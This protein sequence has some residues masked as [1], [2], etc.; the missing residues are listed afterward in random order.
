MY[1]Y[2]SDPP[3]SFQRNHDHLI[4]ARGISNRL[5]QQ[6]EHRNNTRKCLLSSL[7][8]SAIGIPILI[9]VVDFFGSLCDHSSI[10]TIEFDRF[11][12]FLARWNLISKSY[13]QRS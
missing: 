6:S 2:Y 3:I 10:H 5:R 7:V 9:L 8:I 13:Y 1:G 11:F 12:F 4:Y